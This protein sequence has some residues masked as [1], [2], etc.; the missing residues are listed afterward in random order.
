MFSSRKESK[1][2]MKNDIFIFDSLTKNIKKKKVRNLY[3]IKLSIFVL[4]R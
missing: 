1:N 3:I 4:M 2:T